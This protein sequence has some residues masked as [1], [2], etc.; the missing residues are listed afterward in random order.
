MKLTAENAP[1]VVFAIGY[2]MYIVGMIVMV[3]RM[4][5]KMNLH[6]HYTLPKNTWHCFH[7]EGE[8]FGRPEPK[9]YICFTV[10]QCPL[11]FGLNLN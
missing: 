8:D 9:D 1:Y 5:K 3:A 4:N 10:A 11:V 7:W 2:L 6:H